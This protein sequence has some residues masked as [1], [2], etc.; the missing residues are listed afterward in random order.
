MTHVPRA[1]CGKCQREMVPS[2]N[3]VMVEAF[4]AFGSYY[5]IMADE[6]E[7]PCCGTTVIT[8]F[9]MR[10][11][12]HHFEP[13]YAGEPVNRRFA[14]AEEGKVPLG[15]AGMFWKLLLPEFEGICKTCGKGIVRGLAWYVC[16]NCMRIIHEED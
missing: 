12:Y 8:G 14:F 9:A 13:G 3:G 16:G 11:N 4:A 7:C 15:V 1:V 6:Y 2:K 5:K 10:P